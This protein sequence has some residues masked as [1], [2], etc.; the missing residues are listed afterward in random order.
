M[1]GGALGL[2]I[3]AEVEA[4]PQVSGYEAF[5]GEAVSIVQRLYLRRSSTSDLW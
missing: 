5:S 1:D 4:S 2:L 3:G